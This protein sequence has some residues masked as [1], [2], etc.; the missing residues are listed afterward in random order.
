MRA[1]YAVALFL[2][3]FAALGLLHAQKNNPLFPSEKEWAEYPGQSNTRRPPDYQE[4]HE[5]VWARLRYSGF[6]GGGFRG[7]FGGYGSWAIDYSKG[8]RTLVSGI[9][10]LT[11]LDTRSVEQVV[12]MDG[13]DDAYNWPFL[14]AVEVGRWDL[15]DEEAAQLRDYLNRGGFL[16]V[17]D[18]HCADEWA[19]FMASFERV[20]PDREI[21]DI[22][23]EDPVNRSVFTLP[24]NRQIPGRQFTGRGSLDECRPRGRPDPDPHYRTVYDDKER[25]MVAIIH[26]SD[27]GDAIE[28]ADDPYYPQ[29]FAH[30]A[31]EVLSNYVIYNLTH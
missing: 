21:V 6:G 11:L 14:Y 3:G 31:F 18:F 9:R 8:D 30:A 12:D 7:G 27:L 20:F 16:M 13:T 15:S 22:P 5:W 28:Y 23:N 1:R 10:R 25:L 26:N 4:V 24:P 29:E 2:F 19:D 17:D